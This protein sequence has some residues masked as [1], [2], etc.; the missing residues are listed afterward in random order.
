VFESLGQA[1]EFL[2][3]LMTLAEDPG[4]INRVRKAEHDFKLGKL[5]ALEY[6]AKLEFIDDDAWFARY[7]LEPPGIS[8]PG[9]RKIVSVEVRRATLGDWKGLRRATPEKQIESLIRGVCEDGTIVPQGS[10]FADK[11]PGADI[12]DLQ[13]IVLFPFTRRPGG[14]P[15]Y[16]A[17]SVGSSDAPPSSGP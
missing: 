10:S 5:R 14:T 9:D 6:E 4:E 7:H 8:V 12:D 13:D 1:E 2:A 11:I 15:N 3:L 17:M 16:G